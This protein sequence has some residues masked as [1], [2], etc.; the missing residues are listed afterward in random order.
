MKE[1]RTLVNIK[2]YNKL[3][4]ESK[5]LH[6]LQQETFLDMMDALTEACGIELETG[7]TIY[8]E[9]ELDKDNIAALAYLNVLNDVRITAASSAS[10]ETTI[11]AVND[12]LQLY[13]DYHSELSN[14][15]WLQDTSKVMGAL[16][17]AHYACARAY[18][19]E[20]V[21][22]NTYMTS[23]KDKYNDR[24]IARTEALNK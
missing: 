8:E 5:L 2:D 14:L 6:K 23:V 7:D 21:A 24:K 16:A 12:L 19:L 1:D 18:G 9:E 20:P 22:L 4:A 15:E 3:V 11:A 10:E 17:A 13:A